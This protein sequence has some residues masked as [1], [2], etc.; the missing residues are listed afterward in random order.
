[1]PASAPIA[2][3]ANTWVKVATAVTSG[4]I[5]KL[6]NEPSLYKQTYVDTGEDAPTDDDNAVLAFAS[7]CESFIFSESTSSDIYV[8]AVKFA[9][10]VRADV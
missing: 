4:I 2:C 10:S 5:H 9:G 8:K 1:M 6:S 7:G 3:A